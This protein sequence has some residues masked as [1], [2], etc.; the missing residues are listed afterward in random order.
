MRVY[1]GAPSW[2]LSGANSLG[3]DVLAGLQAAGHEC[4]FLLTSVEPT[5][6]LLVPGIDVETL[7][8][9]GTWPERWQRL[10]D[11]L[12][13]HAPCLWLPNYDFL[14]FAIIPA[15]GASVRVLPV[16]HADEAL[17]YQNIRWMADQVDGSV[18]VSRYLETALHQWLPQ[19]RV[20]RVFTAAPTQSPRTG[21]NTDAPLRLI[22]TGR[23]DRYQKRVMDLVAIAAGLAAKR[24]PARMIIVGD[25]P[26][27]A[28]LSQG[29]HA[30]DGIETV[31]HGRLSPS[32]TR[33]LYAQADVF[34]LPSAYEG[35]SVSLLEAMAAG[36]VPVISRTRSGSEDAVTDGESG[37]LCPVGDT[38]RFVEA[39]ARLHA[40]R[41]RLQ[42][43]GMAAQARIPGR[44]DTGTLSQNWADTVD[45]VTALPPRQ[46][47]GR[48]VPHPDLSLR[49]QLA[50]RIR[51][52][53]DRVTSTLRGGRS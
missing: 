3:L 38:D 29:L 12:D 42:R 22:Y 30:L 5:T 15:L 48:I 25:G 16:C 46:R 50:S 13:A 53:V 23:L 26:E 27:A 49:H 36:C 43:I 11:W 52:R 28:R 4:A 7:P 31:L 47:T 9:T 6:P 41:Q 17:Y 2:H 34:V 32:D 37:F 33:A 10:R 1:W 20:R 44:F 19:E 24:I 18:A 14:N 51:N 35:L 21:W 40:D 39:V 8:A 45:W